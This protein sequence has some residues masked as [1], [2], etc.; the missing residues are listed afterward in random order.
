M[1]KSKQKG[2]KKSAVASSVIKKVSVARRVERSQEGAKSEGAKKMVLGRGLKALLSDNERE[3]STPMHG[4]YNIALSAIETNPYQPRLQFAQQPLQ[5]LADSIAV[6]GIVQPVTVR[7]LERA[8]YYQLISGERRL[9]ACRKLGL[10]RVPAFVREVEEKDVLEMALIENIQ[11]ESLNAME[12]AL[13]YQHLIT[14]C[15]LTQE[16]LAQRVGK[17]RSTVTNYLRLLHLPPSIQAALR[18]HDISMGHAR[19]LLAVEGEE[20]QR[21]LFDKVLKDK[22]SVR[23]VEGEVKKMSKKAAKSPLSVTLSGVY[24]Q[25]EKSLATHLRASVNIRNKGVAGEIRISFSSE[26]DLRRLLVLMKL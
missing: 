5:E 12:I 26:E 11:R 16:K 17:E 23:K 19:S 4:V 3:P 2:V 14:E 22:L 18:D 20:A 25:E 9:Q 7:T 6:H 8:G 15:G 24:E 21:K 13:S 1:A 10:S